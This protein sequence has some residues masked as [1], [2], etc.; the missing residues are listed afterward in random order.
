MC[1]K[2]VIL[3][4][5]QAFLRFWR[6]HL[7][8]YLSPQSQNIYQSFRHNHP[9]TYIELNKHVIGE[10]PLSVINIALNDN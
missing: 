10:A 8:K 9:V 4:R 6:T 3:W 1:N 5:C 2:A 7:Y